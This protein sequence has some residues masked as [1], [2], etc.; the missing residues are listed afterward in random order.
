M[1][2][3]WLLY[4]HWVGYQNPEPFVWF[5]LIDQVP[6]I[7]LQHTMSTLYESLKFEQNPEHWSRFPELAQ[8][9]TKGS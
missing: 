1:E 8:I 7:Y 9:K 6:H 2:K 4:R 5:V 3:Y